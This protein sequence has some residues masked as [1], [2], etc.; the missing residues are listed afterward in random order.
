MSAVLD[1]KDRADL[2]SGKSLKDF[3]KGWY[4]LVEK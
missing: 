1:L 4:D 3:K 2:F